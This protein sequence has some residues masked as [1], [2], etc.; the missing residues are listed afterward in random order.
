MPTL[1][2]GGLIV[3]LVVC[4]IA[5]YVTRSWRTDPNRPAL[6][7]IPTCVQFALADHHGTPIRQAFMHD[8]GECTCP[9]SKEMSA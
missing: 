8:R 3:L 7:D 6:T 1:T 9:N 4:W 2:N 5:W